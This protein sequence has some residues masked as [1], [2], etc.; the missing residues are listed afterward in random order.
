MRERAGAISAQASHKARPLPL[1]PLGKSEKLLVRYDRITSA[2][3]AWLR[4]S[5]DVSSAKPLP[6]QVAARAP[7]ADWKREADVETLEVAGLPAAR[8]AFK[9]RWQGQDFLNETLV[10]QKQDRLYLLSATFP[11]ADAEAREAARK[12][13]LTASWQ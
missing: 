8:V 5:T 2:D 9:G 12:A 7:A 3:P 13:S 10:V 4:V 1:P 6:D 11:A